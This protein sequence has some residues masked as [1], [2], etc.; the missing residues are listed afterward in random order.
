[1]PS[2]EQLRSLIMVM[3]I[4]SSDGGGL[5][6]ENKGHLQATQREAEGG[7][8]SSKEGILKLSLLKTNL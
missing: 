5:L 1:M 3:T 6:W 8:Y 4:T 2:L 7:F